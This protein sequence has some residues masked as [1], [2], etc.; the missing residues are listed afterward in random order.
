MPK[1]IVR[2]CLRVPPSFQTNSTMYTYTNAR[3]LRREYDRMR[4]LTANE[5]RS[6]QSEYICM[7]RPVNTACA[8]NTPMPVAKYKGMVYFLPM[9]KDAPSTRFE[10][11]VIAMKYFK[12]YYNVR[13]ECASLSFLRSSDYVP[14]SGHTGQPTPDTRPPHHARTATTPP[15][16]YADC[17]G[18]GV[19][20]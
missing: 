5:V 20:A 9:R 10:V 3:F 16:P 11:M 15:P 13:H 1:S 17:A 6:R 19:D 4:P 7:S 12:A 8:M 14:N 18:G 2:M